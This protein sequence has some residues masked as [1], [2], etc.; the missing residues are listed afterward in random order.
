M[1]DKARWEEYMKKVEGEDM[2][3]IDSWRKLKVNCENVKRLYIPL[4]YLSQI[5]VEVERKFSWRWC[6]LEGLAVTIVI[7]LVPISFLSAELLFMYGT[8]Y[9][10][11]EVL[12]ALYAN[13]S[14][15]TVN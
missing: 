9:I 8:I 5:K 6:M 2:V 15:V 11:P 13:H 12:E 1:V 10:P 3:I 7:S 14:C 4:F